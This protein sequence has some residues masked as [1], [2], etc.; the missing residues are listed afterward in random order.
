MGRFFRSIGKRRFL[1]CLLVILP[2]GCGPA[3][4]D[5]AGKVTYQGKPL[6]LGSIQFT[7]SDNQPRQ[8][9]IDQDGTYL[10]KDV[11]AGENHILVVSIDPRM[12][13]RRDKKMKPIEEPKVDPK[14]WF[15]IPSKYSDPQKSDLTFT[16]E[17]GKTNTYDID[18]K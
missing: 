3:K 5:V 10:C 12:M 11:L 2:A 6:V 15:P 18:L 4:G 14:L 16:V 1:P 7:G 9:W 13:V 8:S 17:G